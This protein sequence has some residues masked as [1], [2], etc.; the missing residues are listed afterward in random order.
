LA[1][2]SIYEVYKKD[3]NTKEKQKTKEEHPKN[4]KDRRKSTSN[5]KLLASNPA[6]THTPSIKIK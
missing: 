3:T 1:P 4:P 6:G 5:P 2:L